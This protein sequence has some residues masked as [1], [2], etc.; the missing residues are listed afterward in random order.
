MLEL[1]VELNAQGSTIAVITH[2]MGV[3]AGTNRVVRLLDGL[4]VSDGPAGTASAGPGG[5]GRE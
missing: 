2:D 3:A 4:I 5:A 1:F